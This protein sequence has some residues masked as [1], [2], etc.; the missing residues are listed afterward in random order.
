MMVRCESTRCW[1]VGVSWAPDSTVATRARWQV[2]SN[3]S[4]ISEPE[5]DEVEVACEVTVGDE[6]TMVGTES[7]DEAN[8]ESV[9]AGG[10]TWMLS[11]RPEACNALITADH[12]LSRLLILSL[13]SL[14]SR[15]CIDSVSRLTGLWPA[16]TNCERPMPVRSR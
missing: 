4:T 11:G 10:G 12:P 13:S 8:G 1:D 3:S 16:E 15:A 9:E 2:D 7:A 14:F 6:G 5:G